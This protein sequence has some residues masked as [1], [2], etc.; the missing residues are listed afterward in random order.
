MHFQLVVIITIRS[1]KKYV[2]SKRVFA[3]VLDYFVFFFESEAK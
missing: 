1:S 2:R 3:D